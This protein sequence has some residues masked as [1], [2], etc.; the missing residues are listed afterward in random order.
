MSS[1]VSPR[2][3]GST[4]VCWFFFSN[5]IL[6][7]MPEWS[8]YGKTRMYPHTF[9]YLLIDWLESAYSTIICTKQSH[10]LR[11]SENAKTPILDNWWCLLWVS[12]PG[13]ISLFAW[14]TTCTWWIPQIHLWC[15]TCWSI[16]FMYLH[17]YK[18]WGGGSG[19]ESLLNQSQIHNVNIIRELSI[20]HWI[21]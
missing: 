3:E 11:F 14:F 8:I 1:T 5:T 10:P 13:W 15:D 6:A 7:S 9:A 20:L 2:V 4:P 19:V 17:M 12:K 18:Q 16:W 21:L